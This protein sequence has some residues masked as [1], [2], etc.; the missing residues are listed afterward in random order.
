MSDTPTTNYAT[1]NPLNVNILNSATLTNGNLQL[2]ASSIRYANAKSTFVASQFN[3]YCEVDI[4]TR[5]GGSL[6]GIGVGDATA[7]IALGAGNFTTYREV[8]EIRVYPG[9]VLA[10]TVASYTQGDVIGMAIDSTNVKFYKN[11]TLQGTYAHSL[12]GDYFAVGLAYND[13][14]STVIDFNFGQRAFAYTPPTGYN[15]LNTANLPAPT[16]KDGSDYFN[17]VLY[18]GNGTSQS[19]SSLDFSPDLVWLKCRSIAYNH[20]LVDSVQGVGSTLSSNL[21][22]AAVNSSSEFTSLDSNGFSITQ[23]AGYEFNNNA[24]PYVAWA[25]D[26]NG[27]G[28]SNTDGTITST[29]SA[30]PTA[31]FS[32]ATYT[33]TGSNASVGHGLGVTPSMCIIKQRNTAQNWWVWHQ[34]LGNNVGANNTMLELNGDSGTY[35]ADDVFRGFTSTVFQIG[36][37]SGSN[38]TGGTYV[39]YCF[40]EVESYSKIGSFV[41]NGSADGPFVFCGFR[42]AYVWLKGSTFASNWNTYDSAR[43]EYNAADD[44]LRLNSAAAEVSDYSPAAIDLLSNGFKIRTSS[45]DWNSSGQTFVFC[46]FAE[47]PFGGSGVSP[48]T[49]R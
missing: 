17:T 2:N 27:A 14:A 49:A 8:G 9:N 32:I 46:A 15:A 12:T 35:A 1:L 36:T 3:N 13:S 48:A 30:K 39:A 16:V 34:A 23:G 31:G 7:N 28:S 43:S 42:P 11:G 40:S 33:G 22:N 24:V 38:T 5:S 10:G 44:L 6:I 4:T 25:W 41:G 37:D 18:T 47:N 26:A 20:R 19:I 45:G 29:V 21:T